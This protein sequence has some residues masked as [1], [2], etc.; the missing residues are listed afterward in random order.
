GDIVEFSGD[1]VHENMTLSTW[2]KINPT[3]FAGGSKPMFGVAVE[4]GYFLEVAGDLAWLKFA[5]SHQVSPDPANHYF[6]TAW[7][8]PNGDGQTSD[9]VPVDYLGSIS[10]LIG[11]PE[12]AHILMSYDAA[13]SIK[14]IYVNGVLVMQVDLDVDPLSEFQLGPLAIANLADGTG[15]E[16]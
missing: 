1:F 16:V 5:T 7:T 8:D 11:A 12:W 15:D 10:D 6:G 2:F 13:N 9:A 4:R 3:D 14:S